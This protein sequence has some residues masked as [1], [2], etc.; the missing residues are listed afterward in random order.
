MQVRALSTLSVRVISGLGSS[1][2]PHGGKS[3]LRPSDTDCFQDITP[4]ME[5]LLVNIDTH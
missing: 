4:V 1:R 3:L 5:E 2:K